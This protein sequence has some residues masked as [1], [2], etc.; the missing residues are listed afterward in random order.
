MSVAEAMGAGKVVVVS[1]VGGLPEMVA[2]LE[3]GFLFDPF[4][5]HELKNILKILNQNNVLVQQVGEKAKAF[6]LE[7]FDNRQIALQTLKYYKTI[8]ATDNAAV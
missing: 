6:A 2:D 1:N 3:T 5:V 7:K 8:L 4:N